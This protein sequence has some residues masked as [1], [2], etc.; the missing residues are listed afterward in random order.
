MKRHGEA[1]GGG[2]FTGTHAGTEG[3]MGDVYR[4]NK[5]RR[6]GT[7]K[8][9][10]TWYGS[11]PDASGRWRE[12][13]LSRDKGVARQKLRELLRSAERRKAGLDGPGD[14]RVSAV[15]LDGLLGAYGDGLTARGAGDRHVRDQR[16]LVR[17]A[18]SALGWTTTLDLDHATL[19]DWL[20]GL[21]VAPRTR[22]SYQQAVRAFARWLARRGHR[23]AS[24]VAGMMPVSGAS[25][26]LRRALTVD[27]LAR[28]LAVAPGRPL[29]EA[30]LIRWGPRAGATDR[31]LKA[32]EVSRLAALGVN[33]RLLY[34]TAATTGLRAAELRALRASDLA[35]TSES[36][37]VRLPGSE[38]KSGEPVS[39]PL[40]SDLAG[41]LAAWLAGRQAGPDDRVF[42]VPR[43]TA[44]ELRRDLRAAGIAEKD[45][46]GRVVD[47]HSLRGTF[48][49]LLAVRGVPALTAKKLMRHSTIR[50]T[51]DLYADADQ[52][53]ERAAV[54]CL[55]SLGP[56]PET[57]TPNS[58]DTGPPGPE[59]GSA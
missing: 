4:R 36:P 12:V 27:E 52:A 23:Q 29:T 1:G 8:P 46:R 15:T 44:D 11:V 20:S 56:A 24:D 38:T 18:F 40:R 28:L 21:T 5:K 48:A 25:E 39:L 10:A 31:R 17:V 30:R 13:A 32:K 16:R 45:G 26:R 2:A 50:L 53:D 9:S 41:E 7:V 19:E 58:G 55:P 35:L 54:D 57:D 43:R 49:T 33:N 34:W 59:G 51:L 14:G 47:F 42:R 37:R 22:Q 3:P 6:D